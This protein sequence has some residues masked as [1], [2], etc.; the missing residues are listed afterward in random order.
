MLLANS[1]LRWTGVS[2]KAYVLEPI[3]LLG[4]AAHDLTAMP[5]YNTKFEGSFEAVNE[6]RGEPSPQLDK[7]WAR[8]T[9]HRLLNS[10]GFYIV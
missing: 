6:F 10:T 5:V 9:E 3:S 4:N 2:S 1:A 8:Y 7:A